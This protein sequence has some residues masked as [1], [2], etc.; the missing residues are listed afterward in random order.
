MKTL[1]Y[2]AGLLLLCFV[3]ACSS[4]GEK[5]SSEDD[6]GESDPIEVINELSQDA[7]S[8]HSTWEEEDWEDCAKQLSDALSELPEP[9]EMEEE[10][11]LEAS[12]SVFEE[13]CSLHKRRAASVIEVLNRYQGMA[14]AKDVDEDDNSDE[15]EE[16]DDDSYGDSDDGVKSSSGVAVPGNCRLEG[17][18]DSKYKVTMHLVRGNGNLISGNY[19]Y[20]KNGSKNKLQLNGT[21]EGSRV[22]LNEYN[23]DMQET[24]HFDGVF[25]GGVYTGSF[26][27]PGGRLM[28]FRLQANTSASDV[29]SIPRGA[30]AA[31]LDEDDYDVSSVEVGGEN[32]DEFI[33]AYERYAN[34]M[35]PYIQ[36]IANGD[37]SVLNDY[38][39]LSAEAHR[40]SEKLMK[41]KGMMSSA[42][43]SRFFA[44]HNRLMQEAVK[45]SE[46]IQNKRF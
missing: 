11:K 7:I 33:E 30:A 1:S 25:S 45:V 22:V 41:A 18:I 37:L 31:S 20:N 34:K 43:W 9:L 16:D 6:A 32:W 21:V 5:E 28:P 24:G 46:K 15:D 2:L 29:P 3:F 40:Y 36:K 26:N 35:I 38:M 4:K 42:Q 19:Y 17:L 8:N 13:L 10:M 27:T 12:F 39:S 23:A 14:K 44:I